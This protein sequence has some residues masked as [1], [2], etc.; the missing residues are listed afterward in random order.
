VVGLV[1]DYKEY[2]K[3]ERESDLNIVNK[4]AAKLSEWITEQKLN[5]QVDIELI[6]E[7]IERLENRQR[8]IILKF[9]DNGRFIFDDFKADRHLSEDLKLF[10]R[11]NCFISGTQIHYL[12]DLLDFV[13]SYKIVDIFST[14]YDNSIEQFCDECGITYIDGFNSSGL[15]NMEVFTTLD[16]GIRLYKLHGSITWRQTEEGETMRIPIYDATDTIPLSSGKPAV[17]L[18]LY[19]GRKLDYSE[20]VVDTLVE[21]KKQLRRIEY[22]FLIGYSFKDPHLARLFRYSAKKNRTIILFLI[23]PSAHQIYSDKLEYHEDEQFP[24]GHTKGFSHR[25]FTA[26]VPSNLQGRVICLPYKIER[27]LPFLK[28]YLDNLKRGQKLEK[29]I[30]RQKKMAKK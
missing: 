25:G 26:P 17:P 2:L 3:S 16:K 30:D 1:D 24:K 19:P 11:R 4:I 7:T 10:V 14:N 18:I 9:Y 13:D 15:W 23:S 21:L 12:K 29:G 8:D 22:V 5:R 27:I 28:I 6:L 20:P